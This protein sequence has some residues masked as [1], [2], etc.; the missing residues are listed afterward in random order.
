M[1]QTNS[2]GLLLEKLRELNA[3]DHTE[4]WSLIPKLPTYSTGLPAWKRDVKKHEQYLANIKD[5]IDDLMRMVISKES[6]EQESGS[7]VRVSTLFYEIRR[8]FATY[9]DWYESDKKITVNDALS[10]FQ[11]IEE[12]LEKADNRTQEYLRQFNMENVK[13][14]DISKAVDPVKPPLQAYIAYLQTFV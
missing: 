13:D 14:N 8:Q 9:S 12:K 7:F 10:N 4:G 6:V 2:T 5:K 11:N 1:P 3:L